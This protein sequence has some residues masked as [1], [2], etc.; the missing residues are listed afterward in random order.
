MSEITTEQPQPA[1][2]LGGVDHVMPAPCNW[3]LMLVYLAI[4]MAGILL[5]AI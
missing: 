4:A 5:I 1:A 3:R 2:Q